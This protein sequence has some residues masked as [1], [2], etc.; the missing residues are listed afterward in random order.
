MFATKFKDNYIDDASKDCHLSYCFIISII[1]LVLEI[2]AGV[3]MI[4]D[5]RKAE[6]SSSG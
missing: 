1:A 5:A 6:T 2:I 4:I 3:L